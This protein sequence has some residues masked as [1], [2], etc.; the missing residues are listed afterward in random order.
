MWVL[1]VVRP[2]PAARD[3]HKSQGKGMGKDNRPLTDPFVKSI[4]PEGKPRK[5]YDGGGLHLLVKADGRKYWHLSYRH[6]GKAKLL[7]IGV[8]PGTTLAE[9]RKMREAAKAILT[10]GKDPVAERRAERMAAKA[11]HENSFE[12]IALE[13]VG[14]Q[15]WIE[16][17]RVRT[18]QSFEKDIL[19]AIGPRPITDITPP[20]VLD[21]L[22]RIEG[23]GATDTA[24]RVQ[25]RITAVFRY[26]IQTGRATYN[27]GQDMKGAL[28]TWKKQPRPA[29]MAGDLPE[30][31]ARLNREDCNE[32]TKLAILLVI[33]TWLRSAELRG[34][35]WGEINLDKRE[36]RIPAERMKIKDQGDHLVPLSG[37]AVKVLARLREL[38]GVSPLLFPG[39]NNPARMMSENTMTYT[40]Y[41]MGYRD[42]ATIHGFR[43][44][45]STIVNESG[46]F[47]PDA[48]ERQ[49]SHAE[50]DQ[51]RAAYHRAEY[52]EE[53]RRIMDWWGEY[54]ERL[55]VDG[56]QVPDMVKVG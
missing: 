40:L 50:K 13:W 15:T 32:S 42:K 36:W 54:I 17:H 56:G 16:R 25:Q 53:R 38:A 21:L 31:M 29:I 46:L 19:P 48:I 45:A 37:P 1:M 6:F 52:L 8:Y 55:A 30:F 14:V 5:Y 43:A 51:V 3:T 18:W 28:K 39:R 2:I 35:M 26:A 22:R 34:G 47:N 10:E 7:A 20:E 41:R 4:K 44:T 24:H 49:L 12:A 9:A 33:L 11:R 23:R 27:P